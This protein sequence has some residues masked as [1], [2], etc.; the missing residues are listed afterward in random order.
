MNSAEYPDLKWVAPKSWT[1]ANRAA[2]QCVVIHMTEGSARAESAEDGAAYD[3]RRTDGTSTHYFIDS[4]SIVQCVRT[5]DQAHAARTQGNRRGI[6]YELCGRGGAIDWD[7]A[8]ASAM[9]RRAARQ[10]ARDCVKW[11]IPARKITSG[12]LAAGVKG[13][14]GHVDVTRAFPQDGGTHTDPGAEFPWVRFIDMVQGEL[15][16]DDVTEQDKIDIAKLVIKELT[17]VLETA[18]SDAPDHAIV[19][20]LIRIPWQ[21]PGKLQQ[22][23]SVQ[24][25]VAELL[26]RVPDPTPAQQVGKV[27]G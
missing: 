10:V 5:S 12:Q 3:Q 6:Q 22:L 9:L 13:I 8:Y 25:G 14:C 19:R 27:K 23:Q 15:E 7:G 20:N 26:E 17:E 16:G 1:N 24:D 4:D 11:D 21:Y 18:A 2:V